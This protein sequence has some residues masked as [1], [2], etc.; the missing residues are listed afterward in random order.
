ME[1]I[2]I[3]KTVFEELTGKIEMLKNKL[4]CLYN[5]SG[6]AT[7]A[8]LSNQQACQRLRVSKRTLQYLRDS[9]IL[10]CSKIG[11]KVF[12]KPDDIDRMLL[13]GYAKQDLKN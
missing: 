11:A 8:W 1:V 6:M 4:N 7:T 13:L 5:N 3:E 12:Y 9:G 10:P 2:I